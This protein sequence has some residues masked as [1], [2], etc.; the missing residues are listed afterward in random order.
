[1]ILQK[2]FATGQWCRIRATFLSDYLESCFRCSCLQAGRFGLQLFMALIMKH[3][4]MK[5]L[6]LGLFLSVAASGAAYAL[7]DAE[8][9]KTKS[10]ACGGCHGLDGNSPIATY[11]K[12]A[13]QNERYIAK[14]LTEFKANTTRQNAIMLGMAAA[15]SD[16]DAADI[17][18][19]YQS[20]A[21]TSTAPFDEAKAARGRDLYNGGDL[22]KGIPACKACHGP[23]GGGNAG[24]GYPQVGGQYVGYT[25]AQLKAFKDGTRSNDER[26][27]M[28]DIVEKLSDADL[29]ALANYIA[30]IK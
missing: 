15:V 26:R 14:Q 9:G 12:L 13:G 3:I 29:D 17:G 21:V 10:A 18:A 25:L 22:Q 6:F 24:S 8:A 2:L 7:G 30:S 19:Y 20:K 28:R 5:N 1:M 27:L 23:Q 4:N 11:P 16:A